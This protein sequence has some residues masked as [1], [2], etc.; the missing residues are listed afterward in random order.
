MENKDNGTNMIIAFA[1]AQVIAYLIT[2]VMFMLCALL[3]TYTD[4]EENIVPV[5]SLVCTFLSAF[6]SGIVVSKKAD[7]KGIFWGMLSGAVYAAILIMLLY[8]AAENT[9]FDT[10]RLFSVLTSLFSGSLGGI[11][12]INSKK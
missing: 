11:F 12:G 2:A 5:F 9:G 4:V 1:K 8:V 6:V 7:K 10:G 3:L